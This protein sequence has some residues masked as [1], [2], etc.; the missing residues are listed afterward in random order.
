MI[1]A[2]GWSWREVHGIA[3]GWRRGGASTHVS[4]KDIAQVGRLV[5]LLILSPLI[6]NIAYDV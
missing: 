5:L 4:S 6:E 2:Q 1:A 3:T